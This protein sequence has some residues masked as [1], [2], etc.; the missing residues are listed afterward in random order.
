M[1][2]PV[3]NMSPRELLVG[4][5]LGAMLGSVDMAGWYMRTAHYL[6]NWLFI[7]L[8]TIHVY[9]SVTEDF[10]AFMD[11]FGL[12]FLGPAH[13][14]GDHDEHGEHHEGHHETLEPE[15][16]PQSRRPIRSSGSDRPERR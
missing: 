8:T 3:I 12:G 5:W 16:H 15:P 4:W 9:L 14:E 13:E 6:I 11:F 7:V 1:V 10:P 2:I